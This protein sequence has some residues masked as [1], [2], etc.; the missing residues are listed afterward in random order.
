[1]D[2][3]IPYI[4]SEA[5]TAVPNLDRAPSEAEK[6]QCLQRLKSLPATYERDHPDVYRAR[7]KDIA[8]AAAK[9][10]S[11]YGDASWSHMRIWEGT[12][13]NWATHEGCLLR[14]HGVLVKYKG[15][16]QA[17]LSSDCKLCHS[18]PATAGPSGGTGDLASATAQ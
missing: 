10:V 15:S 16:A 13:P 11:L 14:C 17:R 6:D 18:L 1:V 9:M 4:K 12:Y 5:M 8:A 3:T 7:G 2:R